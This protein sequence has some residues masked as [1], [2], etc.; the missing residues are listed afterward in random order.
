[1]LM[2]PS[3]DLTRNGL[4]GSTVVTAST[5]LPS[6]LGYV[7]RFCVSTVSSLGSTSSAVN[8]FAID[9]ATMLD[10]DVNYYNYMVGDNGVPLRPPCE[11][12]CSKC[13][14]LLLKRCYQ[15]CSFLKC[16]P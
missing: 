5:Y 10:S 12:P 6:V 11:F 7:C 1:M 8:V 14:K 15:M 2:L 4:V 13:G 3:V 9:R 16:V